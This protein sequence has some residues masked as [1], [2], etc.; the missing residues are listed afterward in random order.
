MKKSNYSK[1]IKWRKILV[2]GVS[3]LSA[4]VMCFGAVGCSCD[5]DK[6]DTIEVVDGVGEVPVE[7]P[8]SKETTL[9]EPTTVDG[10]VLDNAVKNEYANATAV[11]FYGEVTDGNV[12]RN[13]PVAEMSNGGLPAY[14]VYG[15]NLNV[16]TNAKNALIRESSAL[17]AT[18]TAN[19]GGG[20]YTWMDK[21]GYLYSG[22][23]PATEENAT[24]RQL[25]QH[26][27]SVGLYRGDVD[28]EEAGVTKI[29]KMRPRG[30][31]GYGVT[32]IYAPAGEVITIKLSG[33]D[34]N[35]T[36]GLTVHIGQALYNGQANNIWAAKNMPRI[37]HLLNTMQVNKNTAVYDESADEWTAYV[38]SFIGGPLYI[39][40]SGASFTATISG[41]V[42]YPHFILGYTTKEE[43]NR[44]KENCSAPYFDLEVWN[45]G[46][47]HSGSKYYAQSYSY[48]D[49]YKAAVLWE[50]VASVTTTGSNQ[51]IVFLYEPFVAAGAAVA[52]P[53]RSSV[54]CPEG[55]MANSLNYNTI[56]TSG[57]W[58]NFHEYHHNFQGYGVGNGGEVTNNAMTLVSYALFTKI[59]S[60]RGIIG[61]GSQGLGGWNNYTSA[62]WALEETLKIARD[63]ENPSNGNQGLALYATLLHNFG[64]HNFIQA[65]V[66]G[67]GQ[68]YAAYMNAW[69]K[70]THNNM[71][72][73]F[74]DILKGTGITNN[75]DSSYP[76][77]VPVSCVY[78]TGR[79]IT[80]DGATKYIKTM[81][82]YV[83]SHDVPFEI[84]LS[85]YSA[86]GGQ[87]AGGSIVIPDGFTY[88]VKKVTRPAHGK[89]EITDNLNLKY[90]P[91]VNDNSETSGQIVVTLE[92]KKDDN[93]FKVNDVDLVL[94]FELSR[95]LNKSTLERMTYAYSADK[96]YTDATEAFGNNFSGYTSVEQIEHSNPTQNVNT[97]IWYYPDNEANRNKY[98]DAPEHFF[99]HENTVDVLDGKLYFEEEGKYRIYLRGRTNCALYYSDD[100]G[101]TYK[102]GAKIT[103][104]SPAAPGGKTYLFRPDD[105]NTY[106]DLTLEAHTW[107]YIKEIL[108]VQS[109]P[110]ASFIGVGMRQ[111][112]QT[113]F[114]MVEKHYAANNQE[115]ES[116]D[117]EN[118]SYTE[119]T[120]NDLNGNP[121]AVE[122]NR[123]DG[124]VEYYKISGGKRV[125]S[126]QA[127]V[128]SLTE[129]RLIAPTVTEKSQPYV[130]A[131]RNSYEFTDNSGF[132][133]D[134]FYK[135]SYNYNYVDNVQVGVGTQKVVE[136]Q[137]KNLNL[138]TT[139][140][141]GSDLQVVV[142]GIRDSGNALQL[143]T[144]GGVNAQNP[145]TLV[146][147]LGEVYSVNRLVLYSQDRADACFPKAL[148]LYGSV[149]G[150]NY[151]LIKEYS[152]LT[153]NRNAQTLDFDET[154][155]R[156]YKV[157]ITQSMNKF[158]IVRELEMWHINEISGG[159]NINPDNSNLIFSGDWKIEQAFST[160][161]HVYVGK[162]D[163]KLLFSFNGSRIGFLSSAD[164]GKNFEVYIDGKKVDS[165][166]LKTDN[167]PTPMTYLCATLQKGKHSVELRCIGEASID[168]IVIYE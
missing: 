124:A 95:E 56:V 68:S 125:Q 127:E 145:F 107:I 60:K 58:G 63:G 126:T 114:T 33:A 5:G 36:G 113:M 52:F 148:N 71:Y 41:G 139:S 89:L 61:Y 151:T 57:G 104:D 42:E 157:E 132:E 76:M 20:G 141:G 34:M 22:T 83:I 98:P 9:L 14:P 154:D 105:E 88:K 165:I 48:D 101:K 45:Y 6:G 46:V 158:I 54:N 156:Y 19:A 40:N 129:S 64:P 55:W 16:D 70:V 12:A 27:A 10:S 18:G 21:N 110:V 2:A 79:S 166:K 138:N 92:I 140:W 72:Y 1:P 142:D 162:K 161:G 31:R 32:G 130:N 51:G 13:K 93:A 109:S 131:Y 77:F 90:T 17:T 15:K 47:L 167:G 117:A 146:V 65:K 112:T 97:D 24:G 160:F 147:D 111:W 159:T 153:R 3:V 62:T 106:F 7:K 100:G 67:G 37:P 122:V 80:V 136:D 103:K 69:Q 73:Y 91:D 86:P 4:I 28:P 59:S 168:S 11:G 164:F 87:Y 23:R 25:Y 38:G 96:M 78:Q 99:L 143:H 29:V 66:A 43:Y 120:Y 35:A 50:K 144:N 137:C 82:P 85:K 94:E 8:V 121:V 119:I 155:L 150:I 123:K 74:N 39:R 128:T 163:A 135:R 81:Q 102:F 149:D 116:A 115:V 26:T 108:I 30:Y 53:G 44:L 152:D 134:Y 118:Y 133:S 75:A 49:L 84:D